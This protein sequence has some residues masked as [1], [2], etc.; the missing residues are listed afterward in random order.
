MIAGAMS[1]SGYHEP[2]AI[3]ARRRILAFFHTHLHSPTEPA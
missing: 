3:D 2:S 1:R